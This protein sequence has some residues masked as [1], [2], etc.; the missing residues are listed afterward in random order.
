MLRDAFV[1]DGKFDKDEVRVVGY[2]EGEAKGKVIRP[3][4]CLLQLREAA[5]PTGCS[6]VDPEDVD[7]VTDD[8]V[9]PF[10]EP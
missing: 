9:E 8:V 4:G 2:V 1:V 5:L 6:S 10:A 7:V 3:G